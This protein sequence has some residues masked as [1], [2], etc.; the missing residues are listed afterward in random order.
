[1]CLL[2]ALFRCPLVVNNL[3]PSVPRFPHPV[4]R[5]QQETDGNSDNSQCCSQEGSQGNLRK[6]GG[7]QQARRQEGSQGEGPLQESWWNLS[8]QNQLPHH[9]THK[10][11]QVQC[12]PRPESPP[13]KAGIMAKGKN[14]TAPS[15]NDFTAYQACPGPRGPSS[16]PLLCPMSDCV[17]SRLAQETQ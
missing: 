13:R 2:P 9:F 1:M 17:S 8:P 15:D 12:P 16:R 7:D 14:S 4:R 11:Q 3:G 5:P 10:S 6:G